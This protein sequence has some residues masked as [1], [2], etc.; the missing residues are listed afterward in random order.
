MDEQRLVHTH[1]GALV[2]LIKECHSN[3]CY[4]TDELGG[5]Y[6]KRNTDDKNKIDTV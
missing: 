5:I 3:I 4:N 6:A 2:S 1:D